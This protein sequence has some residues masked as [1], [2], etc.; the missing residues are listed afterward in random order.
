M[1]TG[2]LSP[3]FRGECAIPRIAKLVLAMLEETQVSREQ[4]IGGADFDLIEWQSG[5]G[6]GD[7][8]AGNRGA[9]WIGS[10]GD[11]RR[12]RDKPRLCLAQPWNLPAILNEAQVAEVHARDVG[13]RNRV[14]FD[15]DDS[16]K[17][18]VNGAS[19]APVS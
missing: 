1:V 17:C 9:F 3:G 7:F 2:S 15:P 18:R 11:L 12:K 6:C 5:M 10:F 14:E 8:P 19:A 16:G 4:G 13:E